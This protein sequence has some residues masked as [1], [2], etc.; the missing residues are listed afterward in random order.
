MWKRSTVGHCPVHTTRGHCRAGPRYA[1]AQEGWHLVLTSLLV[2]GPGH[3]SYS[4]YSLEDAEAALLPQHLGWA[5]LEDINCCSAP[6]RGFGLEGN[7][8][9]PACLEG[10][11]GLLCSGG[12]GGGSSRGRGL[13]SSSATAQ[14]DPFHPWEKLSGDM[15]LF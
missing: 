4:L 13:P 11:P 15:L 12:G 7:T 6:T 8:E 10:S 1:L 2:H 3:Y 9:A 5:V 14:P